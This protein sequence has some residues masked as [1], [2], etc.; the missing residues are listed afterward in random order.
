LPFELHASQDERQAIGV[1]SFER[2]SG[3]AP[4][5]VAMVGIPLQQLKILSYPGAAAVQQLPQLGQP[6]KLSRLE[7]ASRLRT[8]ENREFGPGFSHALRLRF[9]GG[10]AMFAPFHAETTKVVVETI[11]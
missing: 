2:G 4:G 3:N 9:P 7:G 5:S 10:R 6:R 1:A 8:L 11:F